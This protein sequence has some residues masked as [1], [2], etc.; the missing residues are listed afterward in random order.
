MSAL[1]ALIRRDLM[2]SWRDASWWLP[3][4]FFLLVAALFPFALG[5]DAALLA[6]VGPG[7]ML[8][9]L[10]LAAILPVDGLIRPDLEAGV[11]D[12]LALAGLSDELIITAKLLA[13]LF[14]FALPLLL[15]APLAAVLLNV[16]SAALA[17]VVTAILL[18]APGLAALAVLIAALGAAQRGTSALA[19]LMLMPLAIPMLIFAA[20]MTD[21]AA[22]GAPLFLGAASLLLTAITPF[23]AG[24]AL[25]AARER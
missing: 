9:A 11:Y 7:V 14:A 24:A 10:L 25:R 17:T 4:A 23:A 12:R 5:P 20:G 19:G 2:R 8:V 13:H 21:A 1:L 3:V 6:R 18:T 15:A 22:R 16:G